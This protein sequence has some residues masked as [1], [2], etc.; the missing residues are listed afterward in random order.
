MRDGH[1]NY[2]SQ[3]VTARAVAWRAAH[4]ERWLSRTH[5]HRTVERLGITEAEYDALYAD[6]GVCAGCG[7]TG[8]YHGPTRREGNLTVDHDHITG[9]VRGLL[10]H[11]C[12][13]VV[14]EAHDDPVI[15]RRLAAYIEANF[16]HHDP[17]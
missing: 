17:W 2:C 4:P 13:R 15:L 7:A 6:G 14:G 12:N 10:C 1:L 5:K 8:S 9:R 16:P 11:A 3:C